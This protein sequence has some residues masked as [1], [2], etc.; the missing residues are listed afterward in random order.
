LQ[1]QIDDAPQL[2]GKLGTALG[3]GP[4]AVRRGINAYIA[5]ANVNP[6]LKPAEYTLLGKPMEAWKETT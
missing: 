4:A 2:Y 5:E 1:K 3:R 6:D